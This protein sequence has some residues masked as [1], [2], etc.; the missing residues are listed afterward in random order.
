MTLTMIIGSC[1]EKFDLPRKMQHFVNSISM[2]IRSFLKTK[3]T[4]GF[5]ARRRVMQERM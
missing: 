5:V 4:A 2:T 1:K 3:V